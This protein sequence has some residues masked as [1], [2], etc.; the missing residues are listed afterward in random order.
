MKTFKNLII[1]AGQK[2]IEDLKNSKMM[3]AYSYSFF[4]LGLATEIEI[5][6]SDTQI[7]TEL[8]NFKNYK[9]W[10]PAIK[11]AHGDAKVGNSIN[12]TI[13]WPGLKKNNYSLK[14][15]ELTPNYKIRWI[16]H[17]AFKYLLDGDHLF[18]IQ[19]TESPQKTTVK[20]IEMFS[21]VFVPIFAFFLK[22]NVFHGFNLLNKALKNHIEGTK[23]L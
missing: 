1:G 2:D 10:N 12:A 20:Q 18:L 8:T 14:I 6:G 4:K 11:E 13:Q 9:T 17:F 21:G 23:K 7:Y 22:R 19:K 15:I 3:G 16:G 5:N